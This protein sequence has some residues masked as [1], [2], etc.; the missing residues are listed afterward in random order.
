MRVIRDNKELQGVMRGLGLGG[1]KRIQ[2][3]TR[4][5]SW[6]KGGYCTTSGYRV[7]WELQ[8]GFT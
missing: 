8:A 5:Y 4:G 3:V 7:Y 2:E 6:L 1:H